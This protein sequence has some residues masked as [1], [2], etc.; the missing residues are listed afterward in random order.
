MT[1]DAVRSG[2]S[3]VAPGPGMWNLDRSHVNRPA[4]PINVLIQRTSTVRGTRTGFAELGVPLD[5]L[6]F[7]FVNGLV[8]TRIRPLIAPDKAATK[9]PPLPLLR[10]AVRLH[11]EMR[12]RR[13]SA[14]RVLDERP[15]R[16]VLAEWS[17]PDGVRARC[18]RDN[19]AIQDVD[20]VS[21]ADDA[22]LAHVE[23]TI[24]HSLA[25]WELH[26]RLH[27]YDL[28][29]I[30]FLLHEAAGWGLEAS[31]VIPLLEGA[32]PSTS[33]AE[34]VLRRIRDAVEAS[35]ATPGSIDELRAVSPSV[36]GDLD[37]FLRLRGRLVVSRYDID[38]VTLAESPDLLLSTILAA[39]DDRARVSAAATAL[40]GRVASVRARVPE[41][42][43]AHFDLVLSE[44]RAAMDLRDDNGPHTIEW[45]LG[46]IRMALLEV[47][48]RLVATGGAHTPEHA[49]ELS[50]DEVPLAL[51]GIGPSADQLAE[52]R[53]WRQ[54][55]DIEGAPRRLG[56]E[57]PAPPLDVLP[58]AMARLTGMVQRVIAEAGLDG[59][60]KTTGLHGIGVG[61]GTY[62]GIARLAGSPEEALMQLEPG[63]VLVVP[64]TTPAFNLVLSLAGAIVT[65]EGG[66][67][68]HAAVLARELGI[69][70]VIGAPGALLE[71]PDG[72]EVEVDSVA[73]TVR[74]L[75]G[76]HRP[77]QGEG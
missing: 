50:R 73:G 2:L 53:S 15:W 39:R 36:A 41:A 42:D 22:L 18:E 77:V 16:A 13:A 21:L 47:G 37:S 7:G 3:W 44:A 26:F 57:E 75:T 61:A 49:L 56:P 70:A 68:S 71:I 8:Y 46:L 66:A 31:E 48:R 30:G 14:E 20:L 27:C 65:A 4:T 34:R 29:P 74:L 5:G 35:G 25:L 33:E 72:A 1:D 11:P 76:L 38:G 52:R 58:A 19:L 45:P 59:E 62:R 24:E 17:A 28:G 67:L 69:P 32:S 51:R 40:E 60:L 54:T 55:V 43:R 23:R 12:R 64:C 6:D 63:D 9:L 10:L